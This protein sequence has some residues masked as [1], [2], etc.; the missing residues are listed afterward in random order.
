MKKLLK[1]KKFVT[2]LVVVGFAAIVLIVMLVIGKSKPNDVPDCGTKPRSS[3]THSNGE[4]TTTTTTT[5][6]PQPVEFVPVDPGLLEAQE[7]V[8]EYDPIDADERS[9][10]GRWECVYIIGEDGTVTKEVFGIP[11]YAMY[12]LE[13][14]AND[15]TVKILSRST[16]NF[17]DEEEATWTFDGSR[18]VIEATDGGSPIYLEINSDRMLVMRTVTDNGMSVYWYFRYINANNDYTSFN[19]EKTYYDEDAI[20]ARQEAE[21]RYEE[22]EKQYAEQHKETVS[23]PAETQGVE[24]VNETENT[25]ETGVTDEPVAQVDPAEQVEQVVVSEGDNV[26]VVDG[27]R[28]PDVNDEG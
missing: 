24:T 27:E 21:A 2:G 28:L 12:R 19:V 3:E 20:K 18:G 22:E 9:F 5:T 8:P 14:G 15:N 7:S 26:D 23:E 4:D 11:M 13:F 25:V 1:N 17:F 10:G 6:E 16:A